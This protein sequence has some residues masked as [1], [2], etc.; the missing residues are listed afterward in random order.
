[1]LGLLSILW[2]VLPAGA[3]QNQQIEA[4]RKRMEDGLAL[5]VSGKAEQAA[6]QFEAGYAEHPYSAFLFNAGVC[7]EKLGRPGDALAKY[8]RYLE[9]DP[10]APD[11]ADV[12]KRVARL[13]AAT[14]A[15]PDGA[16]PPPPSD[17]E[18]DQQDMR[19]LV[20][21][22][23]EPP[24][25]PVRVF[26]P[27]GESAPAFRQGSPNPAWAEI[28]T[29][30]APTSLSLTVGLYHIV[31]DEFQDFNASDTQLRVSA[32]HVHHF[33]ANLS[34]GVFMAFLRVS[35]NVKGAHIWLDEVDKSKPE[36]GTT[37]YGEL[38]PV[39]EHEILVE[40]PGFKPVSTRVAL[41]SGER[42]EVQVELGRVDYGFVRVEAGDVPEAWISLDGKPRGR[43]LKGGA[44][45]DVRASS[46]RH[47]LVVE[48][49][50]RK[51]FDGEIEIPGGQV[52]P[53]QVRMIPKYPRGAAWTQAAIS[54]V[55]FGAGIYFGVE[56]ANIKSDLE[57][58]R[59]LGVL[60]SGDSRINKGRWYAIGADAGFVAGTVLAGLSAWNFIKDPL[61]ESSLTRNELTEFDDPLARRP[62]AA[63]ATLRRPIPR[64]PRRVV[65]RAGSSPVLRV[66]P[67]TGDGFAGLLIGGSF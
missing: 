62:A 38:V 11:I 32:G 25:A 9:V 5:F 52:L 26:R 10:N 61:P 48:A 67:T 30:T 63:A 31:V 28:V 16:P 4:I 18:V 41:E 60:E 57:G 65:K 42:R 53:V 51:D 21:I 27:I 59:Q 45:L 14:V 17:A 29:T 22:E 33:K 3:N 8:K 15:P 37:P 23:T 13:E 55:L 64:S 34:Q 50:G 20:V 54:T 56:S 36:W 44:P 6:E 47:R 1:L 24:G 43:W 40:A 58:D 46:G 12:Q 66:A 7:Y 2:W 19:S 35:G 39:G 49:D